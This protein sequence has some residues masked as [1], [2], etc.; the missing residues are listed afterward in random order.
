MKNLKYSASFFFSLFGGQKVLY[1]RAKALASSVSYNWISH[2]A[3]FSASF[4]LY[5][6][7]NSALS[8]GS[9]MLLFWKALEPVMEDVDLQPQLPLSWAW[10]NRRK[11]ASAMEKGIQAEGAARQGPGV[12]EGGMVGPRQARPRRVHGQVR[13]WASSW[14]TEEPWKVLSGGETWP[15]LIFR[16][17]SLRLKRARAGCKGCNGT[18]LGGSAFWGSQVGTNTS[19]SPSPWGTAISGPLVKTYIENYSSYCVFIY[20]VPLNIVKNNFCIF[21]RYVNISSYFIKY[22]IQC[23]VPYFNNRMSYRSYHIST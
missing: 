14:G 1:W 4:T 13:T 3:F 19:P 11:Q 8:C 21:Q 15:T 16:L 22:F 12:K 5:L 18:W 2:N 9:I 10:R 23:F 6:H 7:L 17:T 20:L